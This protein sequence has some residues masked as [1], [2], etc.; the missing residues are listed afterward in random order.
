MANYKDFVAR[1]V[2]TVLRTEPGRQLVGTFALLFDG[3]AEGM[4]HAVRAPWVGD[5]IGPAYDGLGISGKELSL[6]RYPGETWI[7]YHARLQ[8]A[9]D[10]WQHAGHESSILGQLAAAGFPGAVIYSPQNSDFSPTGYWSQ[11]R[12]FYPQG[13]HS[14]T[15]QGPKWGSFSWG[16]GTTY[17]PVGISAQQLAALRSIIRKFKPGHWICRHLIF[18][19]S[20][21]TYGTGRK[22]GEPGLK[23][24]GKSARVKV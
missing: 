16:D 3:L 8:R 1:I 24:G 6:P 11:F 7:Q 19:I 10:D 15:G 2:P 12:V 20:G 21:W 13:T 4:R 9:W 17:G 22:L 23:W 14:V 18:E 5:S